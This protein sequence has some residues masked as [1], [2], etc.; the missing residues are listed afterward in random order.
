[1]A[2]DAYIKV[3][4]KHTYLHRMTYNKNIIDQNPS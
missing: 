1:M 4:G 3:A 2:M